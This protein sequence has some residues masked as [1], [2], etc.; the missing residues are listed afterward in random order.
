M[1]KIG[2]Q[3]RG[4][5]SEEIFE[6]G[7]KKIKQAGMT[8]IDYNIIWS[9]IEKVEPLDDIY[10]HK[11]LADKYNLV[12]SQ[13][14]AP[15]YNL[16]PLCSDMENLMAALLE[17]YKRSIEVCEILKAPFL[18]VHP[19]ARFSVLASRQPGSKTPDVEHTYEQSIHYNLV[20][21]EKL[22]KIAAKS[23][24]I[25]CI[26]NLFFRFNGRIIEG[27]CSNSHDIL[28][29]VNHVNNIVG[30]EVLGA[31]FDT[32]HANALKKNLGKEVA[33]LKEHL[34]CVHLHDNNG[35]DDDHQMPY[36]FGDVYSGECTTDWGGFLLALRRINYR[37]AISFEPTKLLK[38]LPGTMQVPMLTYLRSIGEMFSNVVAFEE[39]LKENKDK[40][41]IL[42]GAGRMLN[43][44]MKEFGKKYPPAFVVDN[45][46]DIW[47]AKRCGVKVHSPEKLLNIKKSKRLIILANMYYECA[48]LQLEKMGIDD[49]IYAEEIHRMNGKPL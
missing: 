26:E 49:Y 21:F 17:Q 16:I 34:K 36:T 41:I 25:I 10:E 35:C 7:Y 2:V 15:R 6:T 8:S 47:G 14:H 24:V 39:I 9:N 33:M 13:V 37:G 45:N 4:V 31:C 20:F 32:G 1:L 5:I 11:K 22:G 46:K 3:S 40:K 30:K 43:E 44:Y 28:R 29:V 42:F 48:E 18:V 27:F 12:F 38:N 19:I 23:K